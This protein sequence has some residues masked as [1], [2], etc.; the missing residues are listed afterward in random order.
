[1][2][3]TGIVVVAATCL[4]LAATAAGQSRTDPKSVVLTGCIQLE[5]QPASPSGR[6]LLVVTNASLSPDT[7]FA[8][9]STVVL[10]GGEKDLSKYIGKRVEIR[11]SLAQAARRPPAPIGTSGSIGTSRSGNPAD[12]SESWP[13]ALVNEIHSIGNCKK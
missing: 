8:G 13:R 7:T 11:G 5:P 10:Q 3:P 9:G 6:P 1:M 2:R 12:N 4:C